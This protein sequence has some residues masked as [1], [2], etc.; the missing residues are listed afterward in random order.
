VGSG[1]PSDPATVQWLQENV[2][3]VFGFKGI[4]RFSWSTVE[5]LLESRCARVSWKSDEAMEGVLECS[6]GRKGKKGSLLI[7]DRLGIERRMR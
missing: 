3:P 5:R 2:H 1:Y 4:V 6:K 7:L